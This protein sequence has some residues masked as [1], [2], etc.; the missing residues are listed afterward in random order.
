MTYVV[1]RSG[2]WRRPASRSCR[3]PRP[4]HPQLFGIGT[5]EARRSYLIGPTTAGQTFGGVDG[6]TR[7]KPASRGR[8]GP[9][10]PG[11]THRRARRL[12]RPRRQRHGAAEAQR[13]TPRRAGNSA[14]V[15][16][17]AATSNWAG[18][19]S[20]AP[21]PSRP[22]CRSRRRPTPSSPRPKPTWP[23][24]GRTSSAWRPNAPASPAARANVRLLAP[25]DGVVTSRD[26]EPGSTGR[27]RAGRAARDR[28]L[29]VVGQGAAGPGAL[30][31]SG[32]GPACPDRPAFEPGRPSRQG[33][34]RRGPQRQR[35]RR[36][37]GADRLRP[38]AR[39]PVGG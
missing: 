16:A 21:A 22:G 4:D 6:A 1:M 32:G 34:P 8:D 19:T 15:N 3:R 12:G 13:A 36:T 2:R 30:G 25:A 37:R 38:G 23:Q 17:R 5:V 20:S 14:A 7:S 29:V 33:R 26:A 24:P 10:G 35:D 39:R 28:A 9:G 31:W 11:R 27:R 18:R